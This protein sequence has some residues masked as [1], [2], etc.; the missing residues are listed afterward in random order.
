MSIEV[1][2]NIFP[3]HFNSMQCF[4]HL[5]KVLQDSDAITL[6][7]KKYME[8]HAFDVHKAKFS[9]VLMEIKQGEAI[10]TQA[11]TVHDR[12]T[13]S[14]YRVTCDYNDMKIDYTDNTLPYHFRAYEY[15]DRNLVYTDTE[16]NIVRYY[17]KYPLKD[18]SC[19]FT[20]TDM[21]QFIGTLDNEYNYNIPYRYYEKM[22]QQWE[23]WENGDADMHSWMLD[24]DNDDTRHHY[25]RPNTYNHFSNV[26]L[27]RVRG[28][29]GM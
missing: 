28:R 21:Q 11:F 5:T 6:I 10:L 12:I 19:E 1:A 2:T 14:I 13:L 18:Y 16:A 9:A 20:Y 3:D 17:I 15:A 26:I 8:L 23:E 29:L 22:E 4:A 7:R 24:Y 25:I 27:R